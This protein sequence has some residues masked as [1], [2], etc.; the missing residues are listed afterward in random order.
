MGPTHDRR[1]QC[2]KKPK[3][4]PGTTGR[5]RKNKSQIEIEKSEMEASLKS[6]EAR[7]NFLKQQKATLEAQ[8]QRAAM[9]ADAAYAAASSSAAEMTTDDDMDFGSEDE[10]GFLVGERR[11]YL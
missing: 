2:E 10:K 11:Q 6:Q 1:R 5:A 8:K 9:V 4:T 7:I 3:R